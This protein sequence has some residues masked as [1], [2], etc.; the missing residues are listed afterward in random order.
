[1]SQHEENMHAIET[2]KSTMED[3]LTAMAEA[4]QQ[5]KELREELASLRLQRDYYYS[6]YKDAKSRTTYPEFC[7]HPGKC[8]GAGR[9]TADWVCND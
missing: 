7:R 4:T 1:M 6:H 2:V 9:C 8:A 5:L 3:A